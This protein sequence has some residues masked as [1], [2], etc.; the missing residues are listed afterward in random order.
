MRTLLFAWLMLFGVAR[1]TTFATDVSDLW[2]NPSEPGWGVNVIHQG[3]TLFTTLFVYNASGTATWY[4]G[5]SVTFSGAPGGTFVYSGQLFQ[6]TGPWFGGGFNPTAV[7]V[8]QVGSVTFRFDT[9]T[10]GTITYTIDGVT[11]SKAITRQTWKPND[12]NGR[13]MGAVIGTYTGSCPFI[14]GYQEE[15]VGIIVNHL[16]TNVS[17]V[18][19]GAAVTCTFSGGY[20]QAGRMGNFTGSVNC[21]NGIRGTVFAF[22][23]ESG[24]SGF[25]ARAAANYG[26][27]C[28]WTGRIGG[29]KRD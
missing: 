29:L 1:A 21:S 22:E 11:A 9:V 27:S 20:E 3:N 26:G 15:P 14:G 10:T 4:V 8:R 28:N 12:L 23:I 5:S 17:I 13:F 18:A 19:T 16:G 7:G 6:T 2:Y 24:I 25:T